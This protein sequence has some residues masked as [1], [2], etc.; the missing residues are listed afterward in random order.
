MEALLRG[1][2]FMVNGAFEESLPDLREAAERFEA[3]GNAWGRGVALRHLADVATMRGHYDHAELALKDAISGLQAVG[4]IG[5]SSGVTARLAY[6]YA[7]Q[8]RF[9]E[10]DHWFDEA[11]AAAEKQ[12]YVPTLA[13]AYDLRGIAL[14]RRDQLDDAERLHRAAL[15]LYSER[16]APRH[17]RAARSTR[18]AAHPRA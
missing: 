8:G 14:R 18:S 10:S 16:G 1:A 17:H 13:L 9:E 3:I 15:A 5:V 12:R 6:L 7:L 4:A 11:L 2:I